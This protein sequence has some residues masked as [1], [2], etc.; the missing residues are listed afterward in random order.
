[1]NNKTFD[2]GL[3]DGELLLRVGVGIGLFSLGALAM[4]L[5]MH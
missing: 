2:D 5:L 3:T 4:W 1:M